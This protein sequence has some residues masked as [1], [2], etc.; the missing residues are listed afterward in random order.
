VNICNGGGSIIAFTDASPFRKEE[1]PSDQPASNGEWL[2][3]CRARE[4]HERAAAKNAGSSQA[5]RV[6]QEL[7][8][9]YARVIHRGGRS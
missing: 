9:A 2:D 6:H 5:R 1:Q 3:Y 7:A 4:R 8:M